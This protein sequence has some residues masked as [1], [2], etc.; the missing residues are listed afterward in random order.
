M[1]S[2]HPSSL[3][4]YS[5]CYPY[6]SFHFTLKISKF[7][8]HFQG[9]IF[10]GFFVLLESKTL[11]VWTKYYPAYVLKMEKK[12][13]FSLYIPINSTLQTRDWLTVQI[14]PPSPSN[15]SNYAAVK[16]RCT[17]WGLCT[18][19]LLIWNFLYFLTLSQPY[20]LHIISTWFP[21]FNP[22]HI[23]PICKLFNLLYFNHKIVLSFN[24]WR[25]ARGGPILG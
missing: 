17:E 13:D 3:P 22:T 1:R 16:F 12:K 21:Y 14:I 11:I 18:C 8:Q 9:L 23:F 2:F 20:K 24:H 19:Y 15:Y 25:T 5:T 6:L 4:Q 7:G 10:R